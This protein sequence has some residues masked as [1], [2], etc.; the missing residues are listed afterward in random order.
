MK[1]IM[2]I[3]PNALD[4]TSYY[5]GVGPISILRKYR[6]D[7]NIAFADRINMM[8]MM[9]CNA[10]FMQRP[11]KD[12]SVE[13]AK[14]AKK[15]NKPLW[16][17]YDDFLFDVPFS[18]P[19]YKVYSSDKVKKNIAEMIVM[20]DLVTVSTDKLADVL[21]RSNGELLNKNTVVINNG[22]NETNFSQK[23]RGAHES[24]LITWRGSNTHEE[25]LLEVCGEISEISHNHTDWTFN[26]IGCRPSFLLQMM[27]SQNTIF[28][29]ALNI[30]EYFDYIWT[31]RPAIHIVPLKKS[32][33]N[34]CKSNIAWIEATYAGAV[35]IA[36]E[37]HEWKRPGV[38]TYEN[39]EDIGKAIK[40]AIQM[41]L[42]DRKKFNAMSWEY[43]R[44]NLFTKSIFSK[45]DSVFNSLLKC[46]ASELAYKPEEGMEL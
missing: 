20:A 26:F 9:M 15:R 42:E 12:A 2:T 45:L 39:P 36:P 22:F 46:E 7:I 14:M 13:V 28:T 4:A 29:E 32:V 37:W 25:D 11:Y 43:I 5:R 34:L 6:D 27:R 40:Q 19:A 17:D 10:V 41:P 31:V 23:W 38:I 8:N 18:N 33:F 44:N 3:T 30:D 35:T 24:N 16:V 21:R 1:T